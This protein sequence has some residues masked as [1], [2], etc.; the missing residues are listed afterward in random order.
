MCVFVAGS[1]NHSSQ[2]VSKYQL[3]WPTDPAISRMAGS[4]AEQA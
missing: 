3:K 1:V 2:L 4:G